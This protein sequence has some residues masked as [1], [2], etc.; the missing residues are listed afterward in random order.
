MALKYCNQFVH[1]V[2]NI[3]E[4]ST[5]AWNETGFNSNTMP[6][7]LAMVIR[8]FKDTVH[9]ESGDNGYYFITANML[10]FSGWDG[11]MSGNWID[12]GTD[13][14]GAWDYTATPN[15]GCPLNDTE[16]APLIQAITYPGGS[17]AIGNATPSPGIGHDFWR[18]NLGVEGN[19]DLG[20]QQNEGESF[21]TNASAIGG[22]EPHSNFSNTLYK[23]WDKYNADVYCSLEEYFVSVGVIGPNFCERWPSHIEKV[24]A[25]N[26]R[27]VDWDGEQDNLQHNSVIVIVKFVDGFN[28][29]SLANIS[30]SGIYSPETVET[31]AGDEGNYY[32]GLNIRIDLEGEATWRTTL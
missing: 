3:P 28:W 9:P 18:S 20:S 30:E 4:G 26:T 8:P 29:D 23:V 6:R 15:A 25:V 27:P 1:R 31:S 19:A 12:Y 14:D 7:A 13:N 24:V 16:F 11:N 10:K 17:T 22:Y 21:N 5:T 32:S 2:T